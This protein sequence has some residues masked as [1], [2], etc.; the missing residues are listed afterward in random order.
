MSQ[1]ADLSM[2][3]SI[4]TLI[5]VAVIAGGSIWLLVGAI[6]FALGLKNKEAPQIQS[7][8]WQMIGGAVI[9]VAGGFF[10]NIQFNSGEVPMPG[11]IMPFFMF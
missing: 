3:T 1:G 9:I 4:M 8:I 6:I 2:F 5:K 7:G 10:A 11:M